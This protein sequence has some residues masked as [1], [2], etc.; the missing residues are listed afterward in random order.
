[1]TTG[2]EM[3]DIRTIEHTDY[4]IALL[5]PDSRQLLGIPGSG[6]H[7]VE[8]PVVCIPLWERPAEQ[9]TKQ[10][11]DRWGIRTIILDTLVGPGSETACAVAEIRTSSWD[12]EHE[13]FCVAQPENI[14]NLSLGE[15]QRQPLRAILGANES[16]G[17]A[18][19]RI[20]WIEE[21]QRWIQSSVNDHE[22]IF[23]GETRQLNG[24]GTFCLLRLGTQSGPAYWIKGVGEP[25]AHEFAVTSYLAANCSEY[26]PRVVAMRKDWN[27]WAMEDFGSSLHHSDSLDDFKRAVYQL[28]GLQKRLVGKS[29]ELLA[30]QCADHRTV[31]LD[32]HIDEIIDYL[33]G[34]MRQ[35][36]S[37]KAPALSTF[38]L[39]EIRSALHGACSALQELGIPDSLI[40]NDISPGSILGDGTNCVFTDWCEG[41]A[42][43]PFITFEQLCSH[44]SRKTGDSESWIR[45]LKSVYISR[46]LEC[47]TERQI[48]GALEV[49]PL[50]SVLSYLYGRG[51]WL[52][53]SRASEPEFMS[54]S[55]SLGRHMDRIAKL[56]EHRRATC[57][58]R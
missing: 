32:S 57:G 39:N 23:T 20:G 52:H 38:R 53:N 34:A 25:N 36:T 42:G 6:P 2:E 43:C 31:I 30:A 35:Q 48:E 10:I 1:M 56:T 27:A 4:R 50:I 55:R 41:C 3:A 9:L 21:A 46:W 22:V 37:A 40:H 18:F 54:Y 44:V 5:L 24:G 45:S 58:S 12:F 19:S 29:R 14:G 28:A 11:E 49:C 17:K 33:N 51:D 7:V 15:V 8:L 16:N 13:G 26:L 47:L